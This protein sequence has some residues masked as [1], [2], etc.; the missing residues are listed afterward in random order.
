MDD[1]PLGGFK[2]CL[3]GLIIAVPLWVLMIAVLIWMY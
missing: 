1:D 2:G 3:N